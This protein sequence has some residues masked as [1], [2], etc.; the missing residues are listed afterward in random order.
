MLF[1]CPVLS[2]S[3]FGIPELIRDGENGWLVEERDAASLIAGLHRVLR[4][5]DEARA[6]VGKRGRELVA[7]RYRSDLFGEAYLRMIEELA[8]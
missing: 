2:V 5:D 8:G 1:G 7:E 3:V 6:L 4:L